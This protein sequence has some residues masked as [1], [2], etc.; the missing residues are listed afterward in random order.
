MKCKSK[1]KGKM[2][3][4]K[5]L[6]FGKPKT[7]LAP[8][9]P[10]NGTQAMIPVADIQKG[11]IITTDGRYIKIIEIL[12]VNFYLKSAIE[13]QNTTKIRNIRQY[14]LTALFNAPNTI[15][16]YYSSLVNYDMRST[17]EGADTG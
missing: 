11:V 14:L 9:T 5:A 3:G 13:Q 1:S 12:P 10:Q 15:D 17:R 8:D 16:S 7:N 4:L 6:I 2:P